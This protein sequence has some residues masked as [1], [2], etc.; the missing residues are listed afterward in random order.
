M[1][2]SISKYVNI[3][4]GVGGGA[5]AV[6]RDLIL[7]A[8]TNYPYISPDNFLQFSNAQDVGTFFGVSSEEYARAV[9]YF[10][11]VSKNQTVPQAIQFARYVPV[12]SAP[13]IYPI[14]GNDTAIGA[15]NAISNGTFG[16]TIGGV[17][18]TFGPLD[19]TSASDLA[20]VASELQ[21]A[22][23]GSFAGSTVTYDAK[24]GGF[25]FVGG[26]TGALTITV[27]PG[28]T[29]TDISGKGLLGWY[30]SAVYI[31]NIYSS[32]IVGA[33][34][35]NGG[36]VESITACLT[37]SA[38]LSNNFGSFLFLN[39]LSVTQ[40]NI[41]DAATWNQ[42]Q[43]NTYLYTIGVIPSSIVAIQAAVAN[44]GGCAIT[45]SPNLNFSQ[46]GNVVSSSSTISNLEDT[47]SMYTGLVVS[48]SN[49]PSGSYITAILSSTSI[50]ISNSATG[51]ATEAITF[52]LNQFPEQLPSMILAATDYDRTNSVQNY[53]YQQVAGLTPS[54]ST[55]S[56]KA[57]YDAI[58]VNY[59]G[60][61]Q[62]SGNQIAFYQTGAMQGPI[63]SPPDMTTYT[64]EVWLKDAATVALI[65]L[66]LSLAE[67]PANETGR[68]YILSTL[69]N[70]INSALD[71]GVISVGKT[72][73]ANQITF[74][75][76]ET[77]DDLAWYQVQNNGYWIDCV[78][79]AVSNVATYTL[80]YSKDDVINLI[81]GTH[82]LI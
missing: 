9:F 37:A 12:A 81:N 49:I 36:A 20:A 3:T 34:W 67:L 13:I 8:F 63:T 45:N 68:N 30:P 60:V 14:Y 19:F 23:G 46:I 29:G 17:S 82:T 41:V 32:S 22:I 26:T 43:N 57:S 53:M 1:S 16:L 58:N 44:I 74:I 31:N 80:I 61:T 39:N 71:N 76:N 38:N 59:Y 25:I 65:N 15:W 79:D 11:W 42:S 47:S 18:H 54:V 50:T 78:I 64:N 5:E 55:D 62:Q 77:N 56:L 2:I 69:Q 33:Q 51:T 27:Q 66:Q 52:L 7:R 24:S 10:S 21:S 75:T 48:G 72:L 35:V 73:S 40:Q 70:V 6:T 4:S 28:L